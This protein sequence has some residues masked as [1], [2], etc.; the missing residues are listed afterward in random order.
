MC[1]F[2]LSVYILGA[3]MIIFNLFAN[4]IDF[5]DLLN[6]PTISFDIVPYYITAIK[7]TMVT[8]Q[9]TSKNKVITRNV[10]PILNLY[11]RPKS[12]QK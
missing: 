1:S 4:Y 3:I 7:G 10:K 11:R 8:A 6:K 5:I 9:A 2:Y 12:Y